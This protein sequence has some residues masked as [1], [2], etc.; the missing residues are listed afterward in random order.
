MSALAHFTQHRHS[1]YAPDKDSSRRNCCGGSLVPAASFPGSRRVVTAGADYIR[2]TRF[3][4][5]VGNMQQTRHVPQE[6]K[7]ALEK[8]GQQSCLYFHRVHYL[9]SCLVSAQTVLT[10]TQRQH[11]STKRCFQ[12]NSSIPAGSF[13]LLSLCTS[14]KRGIKSS[15]ELSNK[16]VNNL[17][18]I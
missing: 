4:Q 6:G 18:P 11:V 17:L 1:H 16:V 14:I 10:G 12:C 9:V 8:L 13:L 15:T 5:A 2:H 3:L 7:K